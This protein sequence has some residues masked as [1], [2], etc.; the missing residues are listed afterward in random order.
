MNPTEFIKSLSHTNLDF[1]AKPPHVN[2]ERMD[3][4]ATGVNLC[5]SNFDWEPFLKQYQFESNYNKYS[6][7]YDLVNQKRMRDSLSAFYQSH[8]FLI[9]YV[10]Q[11]Y[12]KGLGENRKVLYVME[13]HYPNI[14]SHFYENYPKRNSQKQQSWLLEHWYASDWHKSKGLEPID[15]DHVWTEKVLKENLLSNARFT[16]LF[17]TM[18]KPLYNFINEKDSSCSMNDKELL[19]MVEGI[20]FMNYYLRPSEHTARQIAAKD[21]D[22]CLSYLNLIQVWKDLEYPK[23][24]ICSKKASDAFQSYVQYSHCTIKNDFICY[25]NHPSNQSWNRNTSSDQKQFD[26]WKRAFTQKGQSSS[27]H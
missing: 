6:F 9:P 26:F 5:E 20:A 15:L 4:I 14:E 1:V 21:I 27:Y 7:F 13:S 17:R 18:L 19:E 24:V 3:Q 2:R 23:I 11:N 12:G 8:P 10:G 16:N 22:N 25:C